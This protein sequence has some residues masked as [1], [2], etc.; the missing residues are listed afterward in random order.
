M[1]IE[2]LRPD[3]FNPRQIDDEVL[4]DLTR[5]IHGFGNVEPIHALRE[6]GQIVAGHQRFV[7]ARRLGHATVPV[8]W[9]DLSIEQG[10]L[11]GIALNNIGGRF[12][13]QLLARLLAELQQVPGIDTTL[14][15]FDTGEIRDLIRSLDAR[16][17]RDRPETFDL[18]AAIEAASG[19]P[20]TKPGDL[21]RLGDHVLGCGDSTREADL[22]KVLEGRGAAL[23]VVDPPFNTAYTGGHGQTT[24]RRRPIA[25]DDLAPAAFEAFV[26][27]WVQVLLGAVD[28]ALYVFMS[29]KEWP[30]LA[31]VLAEAGGHW[32]D[33][34]IWAKD[35]FTLG[36]S[37]Y[38]RGFEPI[39]Y[40]WREGSTHHWCGDRDQSDVW[41]I[42]RPAASPL[43]PAQK[44]LPLLERAIENSSRSGDLVLDMFAGSGSTLIAAVRTGRVWAGLEL[45]PRYCDV[46]AARWA[47][48][49]GGEPRWEP[50]GETSTSGDGVVS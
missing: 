27:A 17:I 1:P 15:G 3:P 5:S 16:E 26:R 20:K 39:W 38:Q 12:D 45:D 40:G 32:S 13:E 36:R 48:L 49:T 18:D 23:A 19:Q 28:G 31:R 41:Q 8:I 46:I 14:S 43:H 22:A 25:N 7:A 50:A 2:Q 37:D 42:A 11:L 10:R 44:P 34:L 24:K 33:T 47:S 21:I 35:R 30:L 29:S 4:E 6:N 9:L